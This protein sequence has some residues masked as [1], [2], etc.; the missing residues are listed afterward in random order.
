LATKATGGDTV[1]P[2]PL[3]E[4]LVGPALRVRMPRAPRAVAPGGTIHA[5]VTG[6]HKH[7]PDRSS[8]AFRSHPFALDRTR[9]RRQA[10]RALTLRGSGN[11]KVCRVFSRGAHPRAER[12]V[13]V[14]LQK[15]CRHA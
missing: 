9:S 2:Y 6:T 3:V 1:K 13:P 12:T 7:R 10:T 11:D 4:D 5:A 14:F 15:V 8:H